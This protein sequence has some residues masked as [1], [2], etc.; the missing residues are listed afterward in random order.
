[1]AT[2]VR[3]QPS[4]EQAQYIILAVPKVLTAWTYPN[5]AGRGFVDAEEVAS[6]RS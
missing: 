6:E 2:L 4:P 5:G 3:E 1:M